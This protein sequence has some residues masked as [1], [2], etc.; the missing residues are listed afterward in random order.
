MRRRGGVFAEQQQWP[1]QRR[2]EEGVGGVGG[3]ALKAKA[4]AGSG[5]AAAVVLGRTQL[6]PSGHRDAVCSTEQSAV[7]VQA[8]W[9]QAGA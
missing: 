6:S 7:V 1:G 8:R 4:G 5:P 3:V 9:Q 2:G